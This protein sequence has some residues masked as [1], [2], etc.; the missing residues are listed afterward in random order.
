MTEKHKRERGW[1]G[2]HSDIAREALA[3]SIVMGGI[4]IAITIAFPFDSSPA[5][6]QVPFMFYQT[7]EPSCSGSC[8]S[9][10]DAAAGC[11]GKSTGEVT[12]NG[13]GTCTQ[14]FTCE[15][16]TYQG[17][18][19]GAVSC[20]SYGQLVCQYSGM[21]QHNES[22]GG[23]TET[24]NCE[25][26]EGP[27]ETPNPTIPTAP[28]PDF[29]V[30]SN[31]QWANVVAG[32]SF[33]YAVTV[34]PSNSFAGNVTLSAN[35]PGIDV[36]CP[37]G[38]TC[39]QT[40]VATCSWSTN[41]V[42]I[43][44]ASSKSVTYTVTTS[45]TTPMRQYAIGFK[46][47]AY[48]PGYMER[49]STSY[50]NVNNGFNNAQC[51]SVAAAGPVYAGKPFVAT[52]TMRNNG[53]RVWR[54]STLHRLGSYDSS[55]PPWTT[56]WAPGRWEL[57]RE[58]APN[59]DVTLNVTVTAPNAAGRYENFGFKMLQEGVEWFGADCRQTIDVIQRPPTNLRAFCPDPGNRA[60]LSWAAPS[61]VTTFSAEVCDETLNPN[62]MSS[63]PVLMRN[64][65]ITGTTWAM[66][67]LTAGHRYGVKL[68]NAG[69]TEWSRTAFECP[70]DVE[71]GTANRTYQSTDTSFGSDTL[72][73]MGNQWGSAPAFPRLGGASVWTC[74]GA[75]GATVNCSASRNEAPG[76]QKFTI[77]AEPDLV[78][79]KSSGMTGTFELSKS[80]RVRVL[81]I[82]GYNKPVSLSLVTSVGTPAFSPP[83]VTFPSYESILTFKIPG[84]TIPG[85]YNML[86]TGRGSDGAI[87]TT[88]VYVDVT[89]GT[90]GQM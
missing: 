16:T 50:L 3:A 30:T 90:G 74:K 20:N 17:A 11:V 85:T 41:N 52:V 53:T 64:D 10:T 76:A 26:S 77:V 59:T 7:E 45:T 47:V 1:I 27:G 44:D 46:G 61:G 19:N 83:T 62:C 58:I 5:R 86:I 67:P 81:P 84:K 72:C 51:V 35:C 36:P 89:V 49:T 69:G 37:L 13:D 70:I 71:C 40:P 38:Y 12:Y 63:G 68:R 75:S 65:A 78:I 54:P 29:A 22:G 31:P 24:Y 8:D 73:A 57:P 28:P 42:L 48:Q 33:Q 4:V 25:S 15:S 88:T 43:T 66:S 34:T 87:A 2:K 56:A 32:D 55:F 9:C 79:H 39:P 18:A 80:V 14:S 6:A 23:G 82:D 60:T 21:C